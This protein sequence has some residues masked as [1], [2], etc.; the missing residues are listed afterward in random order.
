MTNKITQKNENKISLV[1]T[2]FNKELK[3]GNE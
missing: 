2:Q 1:E 3:G